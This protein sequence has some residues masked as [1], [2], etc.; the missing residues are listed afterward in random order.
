[1]PEVRLDVAIPDVLPKTLPV[2]ALRRGVLLPGG[3]LPLTVGRRR[4]LAALD[5]VRDEL[6]LVVPQREAADEPAPSDLLPIATLAR[7]VSTKDDARGVRQV[8]VQG[9]CRVQLTGFPATH[10]AIE[11]AFTRLEESWPEGADADAMIGAFRESV[12]E[13]AEAIGQQTPAR[14]LLD[15]P[16]DPPLLVDA[17]AAFLQEDDGWKKEV[18][19]TR[20]P[21]ARAEEVLKALVRVREVLAARRSIHDRVRS[22][23]QQQQK[24][25]LLRQQLKAIQEELGEV[26]EDDDLARLRARL[27]EADLPDEVRTVVD[28]ELRRMERIPAQSP[29]RG[30]AVDWLEWVAD[31]PWNTES[32]LDVDLDA[33][34]QALDASH[35]GLDDVKRQ[36]VEHLAVR[37]LAGRGRADVLLLVGP[38]GVG[39]TSIAQAIAD[40]TG[41][42]LVRVA[43]GGMR[44]EAE[45]RGHRRTYIGARPGRLVEGIRKAGTVDPVV[46]LDEV[47]KV[48]NSQWGNP[49]AALLEILDP[50]QNHHFVDHYME[51]PVDLSRAL[52]VA[53]ANDLGSIP[54]PLRDRL[55]I[56][57]I[58]GYSPAEKRVI[59]REHLLPRLAENA[60]VDE[61]MVELTDAAIDDAIAGWTREAG[62]R[63]LQRVLGK[64]FRAAAVKVARG[65]LDEPLRVDVDDLP[66]YLGRRKVREQAH[67][68]VDRPGIATGLAWTPVGGD[69][70]YVEASTLPGNGRLHLTGQLGD[71]M[72]ESARAALTYVLAHAE[73]LGIPL[74]VLEDHDVHIHVPAGAVPKDGPSAGVTMFTA[75]ASLL[76]GR[77][78]APDVAMT[79]EASLRGRVLAVGGI[80]SKVLAAH[81][82]GLTRVILP[83]QNEPDLE[84]LPDEVREAMEIVLVDHMSEVLDRALMPADAGQRSARDV[85]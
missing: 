21:V 46:L 62:V 83:R 5:A 48:G 24:E 19:Q 59:A 39:K 28:R 3:V 55:E 50:E 2:L 58:A 84:D 72:K 51:V 33:L 40:A 42:K 63:S 11:A 45:L 56:L 4:S 8:L 9:L 70:L 79:G 61:A 77:N 23:T 73:S 47:D 41:R 18:L 27:D 85:A 10:P 38:P 53:T 76:S 74:D 31:F 81:R 34:E 20:D 54:A 69:V 36:V 82:K 71:V 17:V 37:K 65:S 32:A 75:L 1:M 26:D 15:A 14:A 43:L 68:V 49:A 60:G 64:V 29:E 25:Y 80:P 78:V 57:E 30:T 6:L 12:V 7:V 52:F 44:D 35:H 66:T 22:E 67:E 16:F 13:T